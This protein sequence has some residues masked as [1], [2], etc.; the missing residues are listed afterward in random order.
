LKKIV[1]KSA[2]DDVIEI[3]Q[4]LA[5]WFS[6][7]R[8]LFSLLEAAFE[9]GRSPYQLIGPPPTVAPKGME[10]EGHSVASD[11]AEIEASSAKG[12]FTHLVSAA[13]ALNRNEPRDAIRE[14]IHA[15]ESAAKQI[16][17]L[18]KATLPDALRALQR[19]RG[20]HPALREAFARL[21]S[22]TSD[23]KGIRHALLNSDNK[24]VGMDEALFMFSAS[25][26]FVSFL[27]RKFPDE[28][29]AS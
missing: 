23:E 11:L 18:E 8:F 16:T 4:S 29:I 2:Y 24:D 12:A 15:V 27:A 21:Y 14:S 13:E 20:L 25:A 6:D 5:R 28:D 17:G 3:V 9:D 22:Y 1:L 26:A 7:D 10:I 19:Q